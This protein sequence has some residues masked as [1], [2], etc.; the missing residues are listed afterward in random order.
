VEAE[1]VVE[2]LDRAEATRAVL[3]Q[4]A[5]STVLGGKKATQAFNKKVKELSG[6]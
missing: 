6:D 3:L 4:M 2:R 5:V 1:Y